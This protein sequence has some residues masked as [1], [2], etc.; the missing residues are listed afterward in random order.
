MNQARELRKRVQSSEPEPSKRQRLQSLSAGRNKTSAALP[1]VIS[2]LGQDQDFE[3]WYCVVYGQELTHLDDVNQPTQTKPVMLERR[4]VEFY[5]SPESNQHARLRELNGLSQDIPILGCSD[6][7]YRLKVKFLQPR[8]R[9]VFVLDESSAPEELL[10]GNIMR[11]FGVQCERLSDSKFQ[12]PKQELLLDE[13]EMAFSLR[14]QAQVAK[15]LDLSHGQCV[16]MLYGAQSKIGFI[17]SSRL[18][19]QWF[20]PE[21]EGYRLSTAPQ[22]VPVGCLV[23][24]VDIVR[25]ANGLWTYWRHSLV[26]NPSIGS[27]VAVMID[28]DTT[29]YGRVVKKE[30]Q[31]RWLDF[32]EISVCMVDSDLVASN[33]NLPAH[34]GPL[35]NGK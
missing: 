29:R 18:T 24:S 35:P 2:V 32:S 33:A 9:G 19:V 5:L 22:C 27:C 34:S 28:A 12:I 14:V 7:F 13:E 15:R 6:G 21:T 17:E 1:L 16:E 8:G 30:L 26:D 23:K 3:V 4:N 31:L 25:A 10:M 20:E 11:K